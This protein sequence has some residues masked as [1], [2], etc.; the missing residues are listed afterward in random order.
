MLWNRDEL[1]GKTR[2]KPVEAELDE[3]VR[4]LFIS[5]KVVRFGSYYF[6]KRSLF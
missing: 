6:Y 3:S 4:T 1:V 5:C 2:T